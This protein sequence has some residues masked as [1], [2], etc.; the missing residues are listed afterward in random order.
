[1]DY[2]IFNDLRSSHSIEGKRITE[3]QIIDTMDM[4]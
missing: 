2:F 1:M 3:E 4:V